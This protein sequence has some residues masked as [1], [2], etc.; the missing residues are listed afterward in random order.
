MA[1]FNSVRCLTK[2][3]VQI[4]PELIHL[5]FILGLEAFPIH[6]AEEIASNLLTFLRATE[7]HTQG[8]DPSSGPT[9]L[10]CETHSPIKRRW[11]QDDKVTLY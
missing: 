4:L 11:K 1:F 8:F 6:L 7:A 5:G 10:L 2:E 3:W 9:F